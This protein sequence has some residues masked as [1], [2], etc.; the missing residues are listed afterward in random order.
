MYRQLLTVC[1]LLSLGLF[2]QLASAG[3]IIDP[4][5]LSPA[6]LDMARSLGAVPTT[7][8]SQKDTTATPKPPPPVIPAPQTE[9]HKANDLS[10]VF[11]ANLFTGAFIREGSARFNPEYLIQIGD[12][13]IIYTEF[14]ENIL[15]SQ[16]TVSVN[17]DFKNKSLIKKLQF[18]I[19]E[20]LVP[21]ILGFTE[22]QDFRFVVCVLFLISLVLG[23]ILGVFPLIWQRYKYING[24]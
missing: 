22:A 13:I 17:D 10:N 1:L 23:T 4:S 18:L 20:K 16:S 6:Q 8:P 19:D 9:D 7:L 3:G 2:N 5:T 15:N 11:G 12:T 24:W 21:S 14:E